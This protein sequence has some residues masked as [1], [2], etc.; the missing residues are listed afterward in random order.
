[1]GR[2]RWVESYPDDEVKLSNVDKLDPGTRRHTHASPPLTSTAMYGAPFFESRPMHEGNKPSRAAA[3][4]VLA[5]ERVPL[6]IEPSAL[7]PISAETTIAAACAPVTTREVSIA[8]TFVSIIAWFVSALKYEMLQSRYD[9]MMKL[10]LIRIAGKVSLRTSCISSAIWLM[11][12]APLFECCC[13]F[14]ERVHARARNSVECTN[15]TLM[16]DGGSL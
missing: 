1:M 14:A 5:P 11:M 4:P 12:P 10:R 8:T 9:I 2:E 6:N 16:S 15:Q 13:Y 7:N 3:Y